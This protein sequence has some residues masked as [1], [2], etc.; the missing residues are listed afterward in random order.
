[1]FGYGEWGCFYWIE[2]GELCS[3][4]GYFL[5]EEVVVCGEFVV[6]KVGFCWVIL[7]CGGYNCL[8]EIKLVDDYMFKC[9][10]IGSCIC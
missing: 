10:E 1:M 8:I 5:F 4:F 6:M 9:F 3:Y 7:E 2:N